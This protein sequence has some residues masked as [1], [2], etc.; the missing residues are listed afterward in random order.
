[1]NRLRP[2]HFVHLFGILSGHISSHFN[3]LFCSFMTQCP[4]SSLLLSIMKGFLAER[5]NFSFWPSDWRILRPFVRTLCNLFHIAC[6]TDIRFLM[7]RT[8]LKDILCLLSI[9]VIKSL[10]MWINFTL[11]YA[12]IPW[13]FVK[14][15][16]LPILYKKDSRVLYTK[17]LESVV[18]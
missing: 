17:Y 11:C 7:Q 3:W 14:T 15:I 2:V 4:S 6:C 5:I 12:A 1:M 10:V 8:S 16:L 13:I 18:L 9:K